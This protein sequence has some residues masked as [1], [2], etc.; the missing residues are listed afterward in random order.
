MNYETN[1]NQSGHIIITFKKANAG[2]KFIFLYQRKPD[3]LRNLLPSGHS[4]MRCTLWRG[5]LN[6]AN[7]IKIQA[8]TFYGEGTYC[9]TA[10]KTCFE[11]NFCLE[12]DEFTFQIVKRKIKCENICELSNNSLSEMGWRLKPFF[13]RKQNRFSCNSVFLPVAGL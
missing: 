2:F 8:K 4:F 3:I 10:Q 7:K 5:K 9:S 13:W 1:A 11:I 6:V 12:N